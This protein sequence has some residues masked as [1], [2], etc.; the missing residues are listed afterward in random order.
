MKIF[1]FTICKSSKPSLTPEQKN[2][3]NTSTQGS[4]KIDTKTRRVSIE[5][6]FV[7]DKQNLDSFMGLEFDVVTGNFSCAHNQ[8]VSL[9]GGP[10]KVGG[11]FDCTANPLLSLEGAPL[12]IGG[13]LWCDV[14]GLK[15]VEWNAAGFQEAKTRGPLANH[16]IESFLNWKSRA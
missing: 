13:T 11:N 10:R 3:L 7:C 8:L 4:W 12:E 14:F 1:G 2:F 6:N 5:G 9:I 15:S 16:M